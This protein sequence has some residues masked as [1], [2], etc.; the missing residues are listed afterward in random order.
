MRLTAP[1]VFKHLLRMAGAIPLLAAATTAQ[2]RP[3]VVLVM[4]DD[5]GWGQTGYNGNPVLQTPNLDA[6]AKNGVRFDRF[7]AGGP[8]CSPTRATVLT[9]R[10]HDRGG[11]LD[12]GYSMHPAERTLAQVLRE[13][14]YR[15]GHFGKWHLGGIRG[16][17]VPVIAEDNLNPGAFGFDRWISETNYF[18]MNPMLGHQGEIKTHR[19]DSSEVIVD[20]ALG[21]IR[22][23]A[24]QGTPFL[25]VIWAGSP[26]GPFLASAED[27]APFKDLDEKSRHHYGELVAFD[28]SIGTL[29]QGLRD[30]GLEKD[31]I[32]WFCSDNGGLAGI[33]PSSTGGLRGH[34]GSLW[35]G[36][37]RVPG[38]V[39]WPGKLNPTVTELPASTLDI[40]PTLLE[41][42]EL[43][44]GSVTRPIDGISL[45]PLLAQGTVQRP[46]PIPFRFR[47]AGA[48]IDNRFK[49]VGQGPDRDRFELFDLAADPGEKTN[50]ASQHPDV[51]SRLVSLYQSW[52]ASVVASQ[53]GADYPPGDYPEGPDQL[54]WA[55]DPRYAPYLEQIRSHP[56][57]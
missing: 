14:G 49:L 45:A 15:T 25:A 35:E 27:G 31:T 12:H 3:N 2:A 42:L 21:F 19:G 20:L 11:V 16:P 5:Q 40:L 37:I 43:P 47:G 39:E 55:Q 28:R 36:G 23:S 17:G 8:V 51:F 41:W 24:S 13:N 46:K 9:G 18:D 29:R 26:H 38:L 22:E 56:R 53:K 1:Q 30:L 10:A 50:V 4:T 34:K 6:L 44:A 54:L 57:P 33:Q 32:L 48:L 52:S 7:Y